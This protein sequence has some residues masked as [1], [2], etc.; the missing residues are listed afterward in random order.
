M[1]L[2]WESGCC[3]KTTRLPVWE[4]NGPFDFGADF[5]AAITTPDISD[6]MQKMSSFFW[7]LN[8][9]QETYFTL[10]DFFC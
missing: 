2:A 5:G 9:C 8:I 3:F 4:E 7:K 1:A 6:N 10:R